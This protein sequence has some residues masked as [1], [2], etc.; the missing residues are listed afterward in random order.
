[1]A[2]EDTF[3][4]AFGVVLWLVVA[5]TVVGVHWRRTGGGTGLVLAYM[6]SLWTLH[7]VAVPLYLLP[8]YHRQDDYFVRLGFEQSIYAVSAFGCGSLVIAPLVSRFFRSVFARSFSYS[9]RDVLPLLY[10]SAGAIA[11]CLLSA[12]GSIPT[13]TALVA[14][15]QYLFV[16]GLCLKCRISWQQHERHKFLLWLGVAFTLPFITILSRGF[17]GY[18]AAAALTVGTFVA[19]FF[20]PRWKTALVSLVLLYIGFSFYVNYMR[21]RDDIRRAVWGGQSLWDRVERVGTTLGNFEWFDPRSEQHLWRIDDRLNQNVLVGAAVNLM[22][23]TGNYAYGRTVGDA[24]LALIPRALWP[25]KPIAAGSGTLV[26]EYT[27]VTFGEETSV[28]IGQVLEFYINFGTPGVVIGFLIFGVAVSGIDAIATS[29]LRAQNWQGFVMWYLVGISCL[30]VGG[31]LVEVSGSAGAS[32]VSAMLLN[33]WLLPRLQKRAGDP[34]P[35]QAPQPLRVKH[36]FPSY[37]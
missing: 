15:G 36:P 10:L 30:Q 6:L 18:G 32:L 24:V 2:V 11:Y 13:L 3:P 12:M 20:R 34:P 8:G 23:Y 28:G 35:R 1:V 5:V 4:F 7:W 29:H 17:M 27:G 26:S 31:S 25:E 37:E 33:R 22:Q 16:A 14:S 9:P 21:D 19:S